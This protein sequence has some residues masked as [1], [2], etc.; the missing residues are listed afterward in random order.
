MLNTNLNIRTSKETKDKANEIFNK[1]GLTMTS[2]INIFL[3][4][5]IRKNGIPFELK[6]EEEP[7]EI[8]LEAMRESDRIAKD[9]TVKGYDSIEELRKALEV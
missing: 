7:N 5:A 6:L 1:L 3:K 9:E 8:T 4:T 2:A